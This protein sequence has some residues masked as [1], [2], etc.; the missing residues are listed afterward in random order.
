MQ[1]RRIAT[2]VTATVRMGIRTGRTIALTRMVC[3][4]VSGIGKE[5]VLSS[6]ED[7]TATIRPI[8]L[9]TTAVT[10]P[11]NGAEIATGIGIG[12]DMATAHTTMGLTTVAEMLPSRLA[13]R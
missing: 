5:I 13:T 3:R 8:R 2:G 4:M 7:G 6:T 1:P 12:M 11:D 9:D 10:A